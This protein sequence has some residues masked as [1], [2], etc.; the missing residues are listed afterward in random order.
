MRKD[1]EKKR[2]QVERKE[3]IE[4]LDEDKKREGGRRKE[5]E[6]VKIQTKWRRSD[7]SFPPWSKTFV[8]V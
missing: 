3:E 5:K 7:R 4:Y 8:L 2:K 1:W 6:E